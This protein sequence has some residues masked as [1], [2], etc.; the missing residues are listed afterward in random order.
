MALPTFG[1]QI[2]RSLKGL[3]CS[4]EFSK[5]NRKSSHAQEVL[6]GGLSSFRNLNR[7]H[8]SSMKIELQR[9]KRAEPFAQ[10]K[11]IWIVPEPLSIKTYDQCSFTC[12]LVE[13][14]KNEIA[15]DVKRI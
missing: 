5:C 6:V 2:Y 7:F 10:R 12:V 1:T 4:L 15:L 3:F 9:I 14:T 13:R 11:R 8:I